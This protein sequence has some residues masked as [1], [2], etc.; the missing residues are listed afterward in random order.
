[1]LRM[2]GFTLG[3]RLNKLPRV[4]Q[5][6]SADVTKDE[7]VGNYENPNRGLLLY[8]LRHKI[9]SVRVFS[10]SITF[11]KRHS[12]ARVWSILSNIFSFNI[13]VLIRTKSFEDYVYGYG[14]RCFSRCVWTARSLVF[15]SRNSLSLRVI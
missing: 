5:T 13:F 2:Y 7:V 1:M 10:M 3:W 12:S 15:K 9:N 11:P 6:D 14:F 4:Y 8:P